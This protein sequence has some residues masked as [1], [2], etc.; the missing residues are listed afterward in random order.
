MKLHMTKQL[1][2]TKPASTGSRP[3]RRRRLAVAALAILALS[4]TAARADIAIAVTSLEAKSITFT[5][6]GEWPAWPSAGV[7]DSDQY[8]SANLYAWA[9]P[10]GIAKPYTDFLSGLEW[11]WGGEGWVAVMLGSGYIEGTIDGGALS[12][13]TTGGVVVGTEGRF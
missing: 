9:S 12:L 2:M 8:T 7:D 13:P 1:H 11:D 5:L 6:S 4:A 3:H 10:S